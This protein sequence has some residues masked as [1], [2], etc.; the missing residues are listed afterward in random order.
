MQVPGLTSPP[1]IPVQIM[2]LK[3]SVHCLFAQRQ[4]KNSVSC[5]VVLLSGTLQG[6]SLEDSTGLEP[7]LLVTV[8][9][10]FISLPWATSLAP[11]P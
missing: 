11:R 4:S 8:P 1:P 9:Q 3:Q 10:V 5:K 6:N 2:V 7:E